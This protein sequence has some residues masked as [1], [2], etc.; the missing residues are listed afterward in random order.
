L[1]DLARRAQGEGGGEGRRNDIQTSTP[2]P[3]TTHNINSTNTLG[4]TFTTYQQ[5]NKLQHNYCI[6]TWGGGEGVY[7]P[8]P[9]LQ[10]TASYSLVNTTHQEATPSIIY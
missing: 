8:P 4:T 5:N 3:F 1:S 10:S 7:P 6:L 9:S 2:T